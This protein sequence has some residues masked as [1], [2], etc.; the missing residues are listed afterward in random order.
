MTAAEPAEAKPY[1]GPDSYQIEDGGLFFGRDLV[2]EELVSRI[3]SFPLTVLHAQSGAGK[4]SMINARVIPQLELRGWTA[5]R[6]RP[7]DE[8]IGSFRSGVVRG[9]IPSVRAEQEALVR[10]RTELDVPATGT[11]QDLLERYDGLPQRDLRRRRLVSPVSISGRENEEPEKPLFCRLLRS[12][13]E[14]D[15]YLRHLE[16]LGSEAPGSA[17]A[18]APESGSQLAAFEARLNRLEDEGVTRR[19]RAAL[20]EPSDGL[21]PFLRRAAAFYQRAFPDFGLVVIVD[22]FEELFTRFVDVALVGDEVAK[23]VLDWRLRH[24]FLDEIGAVYDQLVAT[25]SAP[26]SGSGGAAEPTY[27]PVRLVI[28]MRDEYL[29]NLDQLRRVRPRLDAGSSFYHLQLLQVD[30]ARKAIE[31]PARLFGYRYASNCYERIIEQ[32][33]KEG[34][35]VEPAHIQIVCEKLWSEKGK[36]L[37]GVGGSETPATGGQLP[38]V[39]LTTF[40]GLDETRGILR[41]YFNEFLAGQDADDQLIALEMLDSLITTSRTRNILERRQLENEP[42]RDVAQRRAILSRLVNRAIVRIEPRLGG[43]FVEITHEFL[44]V[45]IREQIHAVLDANTEYQA[46]GAALRT[47]KSLSGRGLSARAG[48]FLRQQDFEALHRYERFVAWSGWTTELMFRS[49]LRAGSSDI[50]FWMRRFSAL[51]DLGEPTSLIGR[52]KPGAAAPLTLEE[53]RFLTQRTPDLSPLSGEALAALV[54]NY[55]T[56]AQDRDARD[57]ADWTRRLATH[58]P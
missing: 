30:D 42:F 39:E 25:S 26:P 8:P 12:R 14:V 9:L 23:G 24:N 3:L 19:L 49:A 2:A 1:K 7:Q 29:A 32:L 53:L 48:V 10:A 52:L 54:R 44:I 40:V 13:L 58:G 46:F 4:T 36:E 45:P 18:P 20:E 11:L 34:Q 5:F 50:V 28:S 47:L 31:E 57:L 38:E 55:I 41:A 56:E 21:A 37:A 27:L 6:V 16:L 33:T 43:Q 15:Q 17:A 35:F 22:Q 51:P